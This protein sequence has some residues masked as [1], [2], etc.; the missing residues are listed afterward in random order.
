MHM[1][2][3]ERLLEEGYKEFLRYKRN[4]PLKV[5]KRREFREEMSPRPKQITKNKIMLKLWRKIPP[6]SSINPPKFL[7]FSPDEKRII[8]FYGSI[9]QRESFYLYIREQNQE[10]KNLGVY[11]SPWEFNTLVEILMSK[12]RG[13]LTGVKDNDLPGLKAIPVLQNITLP[14]HLINKTIKFMKE[15]KLTKKFISDS[16]KEKELLKK[17]V[18]IE[19]ELF[20]FILQSILKNIR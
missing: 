10:P 16:F 12:D 14:S 9:L 18:G 19:K 1:M 4:L 6:P 15:Y 20:L 17:K 3:D 11:Y 8:E 7:S 2:S 5:L 13:A